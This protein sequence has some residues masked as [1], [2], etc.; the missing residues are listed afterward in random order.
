MS[1][2]ILGSTCHRRLWAQLL[3]QIL[4]LPI[5]TPPFPT[6]P[7]KEGFSLPCNCRTPVSLHPPH[8][9]S[10]QPSR[11]LKLPAPHSITSRAG[12]S[13]LPLFKNLVLEKYCGLYVTC[14][15]RFLSSASP[16]R[17]RMDNLTS[18]WPTH[19]SSLHVLCQTLVSLSFAFKQKNMITIRTTKM[20]VMILLLL[21]PPPLLLQLLTTRTVLAFSQLTFK[22]REV[23][24]VLILRTFI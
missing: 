18:S 1:R 24:T 20:M 13:G 16:V 23:V 10:G 7:K 12:R 15:S 11:D 6:H 5:P 14:S 9:T 2:N 3:R 17:D 19:W 8:K 21:L 4:V 22:T